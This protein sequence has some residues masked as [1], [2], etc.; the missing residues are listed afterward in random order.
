MLLAL[1]GDPEEAH[2]GTSGAL[3][4]EIVRRVQRWAVRPGLIVDMA[5]VILVEDPAGDLL[6]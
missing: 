5:L 2:V 4:V 1:I 3:A 6:L